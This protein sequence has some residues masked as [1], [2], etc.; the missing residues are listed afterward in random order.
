MG[1]TAAK[2]LR[3]LRSTIVLGLAIG[4][5][6]GCGGDGGSS[7]APAPGPDDGSDG[8]GFP[9]STQLSSCTSGSCSTLVIK[10]S[11][12]GTLPVNFSVDMSSAFSPAT[13]AT[14]ANGQTCPTLY[15]QSDKN[16]V[17]FFGTQ[18]AGST[19]AEFD[20]NQN[21]G[22]KQQDIY[23][24]SLNQGFDIGMQIIAGNTQNDGVTPAF[25][26]ICLDASCP[27][28]YCLGTTD[29][30][31]TPCL[32]PNYYVLAGGQFT[33]DLCPS[34]SANSPGPIGCSSSQPA[35]GTASCD[36]TWQ[37]DNGVCT[38]QPSHAQ[39]P[40]PGQSPCPASC[41][42]P[43]PTPTATPAPAA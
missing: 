28:A 32:E 17:F 6:A 22:G 35:A 4:V 11:C 18:E 7:D 27:G 21:I 40:V 5:L 23:D 3:F 1:D 9:T 29:A 8:G 39:L 20:I 14:I 37:Q 33:L 25:P 16:I 36:S 38:W 41:P 19:L 43:T 26:A 34:A 24:L 13:C 31:T 12:P 42:T 15:L 30:C 10:S 2:A